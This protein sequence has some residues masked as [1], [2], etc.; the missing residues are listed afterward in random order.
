MYILFP[1]VWNI[2]QILISTYILFLTHNI[3][4]FP[5]ESIHTIFILK[6]YYMVSCKHPHLYLKGSGRSSQETSIPCSCQQILLGISNCGS[7]W[8]LHIDR[9]GQSL[10]DLSFSLC[11]TLFFLSFFFFLP[12]K[13]C[14][15]P[16]NNS[17]HQNIDGI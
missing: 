17:F 2:F 14:L 11:S 13:H 10:D 5:I 7:V 1:N 4:I 15:L 3:L 6:F 12:F 8:W 16:H 9:L